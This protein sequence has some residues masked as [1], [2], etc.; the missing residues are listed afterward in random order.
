MAACARTREHAERFCLAFGI[1][2][3]YDDAA[4]MLEAERPDLLHIATDPGQRVALMTL[5][6]DHGVPV[7]IVEKPIAL[8][9]EDRSRSRTSPDGR[10]RGSSST[11]SS[12]STSGCWRSTTT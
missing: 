7:V 12:G 3:G 4:T 8:E 5:A 1:E 2:R 6:A 10:R 9:A 11:R